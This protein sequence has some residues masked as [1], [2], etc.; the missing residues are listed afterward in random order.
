MPKE[1]EAK[2]M[3]SYEGASVLPWSNVVD[4]L[5]NDKTDKTYWLSSVRPDGKPHA[6]PVGVVWMDG[7]WYLT[8]GQGTRKEENLVHNPH[9]VISY[10]VAAYDLMFECS[11]SRMT[12]EARLQGVAALFAE[13]GWPATAKDGAIDAPYSAPTTGPAPY[14]VY[15]LQPDVVFAL[16]TTE[17]TVNRCTRFSF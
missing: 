11:V 15:E 10:S 1:P 5:I 6:V 12:D 17:E 13:Q 16:G 4:D 2:L 8:T 9:C 7:A 14:N 3:V